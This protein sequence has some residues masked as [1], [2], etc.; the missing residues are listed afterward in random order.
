MDVR[1]SRCGTEYDFDDALVSERGTTVKCTN[2]GHQFKVYPGGGRGAPERWTVRK[3][4]GRELVYTS[5]RDLQ[6]A[7]AQK[8]VGPSDLL[9][10]AGQPPRALGTIAELEPF[11]QAQGA[12]PGA[13]PQEN[14]QRTLLGMAPSSGGAPPSED[15]V[16]DQSP[17]ADAY[18]QKSRVPNATATP[19]G[20]FRRG[21]PPPPP[22]VPA[23]GASYEPEDEARTNRKNPVPEPDAPRTLGST[24]VSQGSLAAQAQPGPIQANAPVI[25]AP[26]APPENPIGAF[27]AYQDSFSDESI[28]ALAP[29]PRGNALRWVVGLVVLAGLAFVGGTLG[30]RYVKKLGVAPAASAAPP[31]DDRVQKL[32][33]EGNAG[34]SRGDFESAK[35]AFDKASA[36]AER[37]PAVLSALARLEA[38]RA[39]VHWLALK[40]IDPEKKADL[41]AAR[42]DL[43]QRMAR[44]H[45]VTDAAALMAPNDPGVV[46][47]Q[48]DALRLDGNLTRARE[49]VGTIGGD[50]SDPETAYVLAA[51]DLAE[52]SPAWPTIIDRMRTAASAE[53]GPGR[54]RAAL[55]YA[56]ASSGALSDANAELGKLESAGAP[57]TLLAELRAFVQRTGGTPAPSAEVPAA[58]S[59]PSATAV[60]PTPAPAPVAAAGAAAPREPVSGAVDFRQLLEEGSKAKKNGDL[61]RAEAMYQAAHDAQPGNVEALAGLGDVARMRGDSAAA[62]S[63]YESV[64]QQNPTYLPTLIASADMKWA[65]GNRAAALLLYKRVANQA[66]PGTPY[67]QRAAQRIAEAQSGGGGS[68]SPAPTTA[69]APQATAAPKPSEPAPE[70]HPPNDMPNVD[71]SDLPGFNK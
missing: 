18:A 40:L 71:T 17:F 32:L 46:R 58:A 64:L 42:A 4:S 39:D 36:L 26:A 11:F 13:A 41:D 27:R 9:S 22:R 52:P 61:A 51:L 69:S 44:V 6:R 53:R 37:S 16:P 56:L 38:T 8:Q 66:D 33:A 20:G 21:A 15:T 24:L 49:I 31:A 57:R 25:H 50:S 3:A 10:R 1:C 30:V 12:M 23:Q 48:V 65:A 59:A 43:E 63:Y 19:T 54:A 28:P 5:L 55:V 7:I 60:T 67:G 34:L 2:C 45:K 62:S 14:V 68:A 47:A 35:E 70:K 29:P